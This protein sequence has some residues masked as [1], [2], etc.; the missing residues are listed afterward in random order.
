MLTHT[1]EKSFKCEICLKMFSQSGHLKNHMLTH[2]DEKSFKCRIC[3]KMFSEWVTLK[4]HMLTHTEENSFKCGICQKIY[5]LSVDLERHMLTH[6]GENPF[7][8]K[9]F[10]EMFSQSV[11]L[12]GHMR[13]HTV[14]TVPP[15]SCSLPPLIFLPA[16]QA[17]VTSPSTSA[18]PAHVSAQSSCLIGFPI[19][20][21][22]PLLLRLIPSP[23]ILGPYVK[24]QQ[25]SAP[26]PLDE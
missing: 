18:A 4:G 12:E 3:L 19:Y 5:L 6:K 9:V 26:V 2:T 16:T 25:F 10:Q 13:T 21:T 1:G 20:T 8:C 15:P 22:P 24:L 14:S 23:L 11:D 17:L 7:K